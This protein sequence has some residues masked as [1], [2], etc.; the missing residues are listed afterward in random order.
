M[1]KQFWNEVFIKTLLPS[2]ITVIIITAV[3]IKK[4]QKMHWLEILANFIIGVGTAY[5]FRHLIHSHYADPDHATLAISI[6]TVASYKGWELL[7]NAFGRASIK[8][9]LELLLKILGK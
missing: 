2:I 7:Y 4:H 5:L 9:L 8:E 1:S 3:E 6:V